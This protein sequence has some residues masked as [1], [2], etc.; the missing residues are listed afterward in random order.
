MPTI[1]GGGRREVSSSYL[2]CKK[3]L[4]SIRCNA[5]QDK[6]CTSNEV[7]LD[8]V[9]RD[10]YRIRVVFIQKYQSISLPLVINSN[11]EAEDGLESTKTGR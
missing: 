5:L 7:V 11:G 4:S 1:G 8:F 6:V 2:L 3:V 10:K 9:Y